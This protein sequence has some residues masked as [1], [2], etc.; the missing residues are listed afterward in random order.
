MKAGAHDYIM[1]GN[2]ARLLP[3]IERELR[4]AEDRRTRRQAEADLRDS[5]RRFRSLFDQAAVGIAQS[6]LQG[7]WLLVNDR[8]CAIYGYTREELLRR[9]FQDISDPDDLASDLAQY[10]RL[11]AGEIPSYGIEKRFVNRDGSTRWANVTVSLVHNEAGAPLYTTAI[12]E[13][14]T[15]RKRMEADLRHQALH[16]PLT[17]LP[18]RTLLQD[19]LAQAIRSAHRDPTPLALLLLDLDHFKE[20]NDTFGHHVGDVLL[21][22]LGPRL[23]DLVRLSDTVARLDGHADNDVAVARLGGDEFAL[24][25]PGTGAR[26]T[27]QVGATLAAE[28]ILTALEQPFTVEG[29]SLQVGA[30]IGIVLYPDHGEDADALLRHADVAMYE[31]KRANSGY[32]VYQPAKDPYTRSRIRL[33]GDL[34]R[35]IEQD[36]LVLHYQ[37]KADLT[38]GRVVGVE[39]LIRWQ[40]P[41][42]GFIPPN[43]IVELAEHTGLIAPLS[44]WVLRTAIRQ[45][46]TWHKE[47]LEVPIAVNLSTRSLHDQHL[48]E[49]IAGLLREST[50]APS[51]LT[52]EITESAVMVDPERALEIISRLRDMGITISI[53]DFGTG[54]SSLAYLKYLPVSE[55]KIDQSFVLNMLE[56]ESDYRIVRGTINLAHDLGLTTVA[57]GIETHEAWERLRELGCDL[58]QGY[59]LSRPLSVEAA[60]TW[61]RT[62]GEPVIDSLLPD[63]QTFPNAC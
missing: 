20:I 3:A 44:S 27:Q 35:A 38:G 36:E 39:A 48:V 59:Y 43:Q 31:A 50:V 49:R 6:D 2:L 60:T 33:I 8:L 25:L 45:C 34:R 26:V 17:G 40:H 4:E 12:V 24:L 11:L 62:R 61:L 14:I 29:Q 53:D 15:K 18:N 22:E 54:Y 52:V 5:E 30:S 16:D 46:R 41:T 42:D 9:R 19:R 7:R 51:A 55:V 58:A 63:W 28:R 32:S 56:D 37:P 1:K 13:D 57:E 47:G 23:Q 10:D 21:Q